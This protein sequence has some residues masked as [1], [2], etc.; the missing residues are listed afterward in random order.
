MAVAYSAVTQPGLLSQQYPP[1]LLPKPGKDNVRLQK[2][3]KRTAKKKASAQT[4][5]SAVH[6]RSSLSP[7]NEAS[8][9]LEHS[10]HS[11][12][13]RTPE[14]PY[15]L[16]SF[17]Q[18]QRF[19]VRPLYQHVASPY[20]QRAAYGRGASYSPQTV[21]V[22]SYSYSQHVTTVSSYSAP[23]YHSGVSPAVGPVAQPAV[24]KISLPASSVPEMT[25]LA[26]EPKSPGPAPY[27]GAGG[28]AIIRPLI[29]LT[30]LVK[31]R[32]PRPT[33]KATEP[34]RS[35]RPMFD[36][37]QI[38]MYTASTT[39]TAQTSLL[40]ADPQR[41]TVT[42]TREIKTV[43]PTS[44]T[45]AK[46]PTYEFQ[47]SRTSAGRPKT[48]AYHV[49]RATTPVFE[50]SRP[51]PLLFA[52]SPITVE[53]ERSRTPKMAS[54]A[55]SLSASQRVTTTEP[56]PAETLLNGD[57]HSDV[58][59][60]AKPIEQSLTK[61][62]SEPALTKIPAAPTASQRPKTP[63]SEPTKPAVTSYGS[64]RPKTPT[65]EASRL[66]TTSPGYKRPKTPTDKYLTL[67]ISL[68]SLKHPV[69]FKMV[70]L[71]SG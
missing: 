44:E 43:T 30:P 25:V 10:D 61:S 41:K 45:R 63:T 17:K 55:S 37:P 46:T 23:A 58:T 39:Q 21:A 28:Q 69:L 31:S 2:L 35:P 70:L 33:F 64:Q 57:I 3:L 50:I 40:G 32:S 67:K 51:N 60:A 19:T 12:P 71:A 42:P 15:S 22:P 24:P 26:A 8:P 20:P 47:I 11:T 53:P 16:Y 49:T 65:F 34:S 56:K 18:P 27:P 29:V 5:Q 52:V 9:D 62:K 48:P 36:V 54:T 4:L 7:V 66:M 6:F 59:P 14:T 38:R 68:F 1:P 13:P